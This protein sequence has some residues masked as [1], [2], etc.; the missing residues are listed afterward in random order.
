[1]S[2]KASRIAL[3]FAVTACLSLLL[4]TAPLA[5]HPK[6]DNHPLPLASVVISSVLNHKPDPQSGNT[7]TNFTEYTSNWAVSV[8]RYPNVH[9]VILTNMANDQ[10]VQHFQRFKRIQ[11]IHV[12]PENNSLFTENPHFSGNN[13]K[14]LVIKQWLQ[15]NVHLYRKAL[16]TDLADVELLRNPFDFMTAMDASVGSPQVYAGSEHSDDGMPWIDN[17]WTECTRLR[18]DPSEYPVIYNCGI[19]GGDMQGV[20]HFLDRM[21]SVMKQWRHGFCDMIAFMQVIH[22]YYQDNVV[23]GFPLHTQFKSFRNSS[24]SLAFIRHK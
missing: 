5:I 7:I 9:G 1:M 20:I 19:L 4:L 16:V 21:E 18:R 3:V 10:D 14:F 15:K 23:T 22:E 11:I 24:N 8:D 2:F 17:L 6:R 13:M 12:D